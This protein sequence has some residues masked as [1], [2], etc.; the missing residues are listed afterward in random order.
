MKIST[1]KVWVDSGTQRAKYQ[2]INAIAGCNDTGTWSDSPCRSDVREREIKSF[3]KRLRES[4][5]KYRT[6][7]CQTS[8]VFC[9]TQYVLVGD[10]DRWKAIDLACKHRDVTDLF[11]PVFPL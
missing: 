2:P 1:K 8:N 7:W 4:G 3:C 10:V 11:Y 6:I 5:I 9:M